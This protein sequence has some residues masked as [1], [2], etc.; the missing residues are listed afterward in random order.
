M[1]INLSLKM[2]GV[3]HDRCRIHVGWCYTDDRLAY[4]DFAG[5]DTR[6][7]ISLATVS[8]QAL[9]NLSGLKGLR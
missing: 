8:S 6:Y 9:Y 3:S 5:D 7:S 2:V 1:N 4:C